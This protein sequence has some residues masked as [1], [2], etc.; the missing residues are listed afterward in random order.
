M[1]CVVVRYGEL[2]TK[3]SRVR[4]RMERQLRDNLAAVLVDRGIDGHVERHD[5]R[6]VV[7][8]PMP[9]RAADA[10]AEIPGVVSTSPARR[11]PAEFDRIQHALVELA[12]ANAP[13]DSYAVR[14]SRGTDAH[15]FTSLE[16]ERSGGSAIGVTTEATVDLDTPDVTFEADVR[17]EEAFVFTDRIDGP[18]GLPV[19]SQAPLVAL[20]SGG[21]DSPVAAFEVM[22]RG[23]PIVPVYV[24]LGSYGGPDH[25]A[26]AL[27][28]CG[29]LRRRAPNHDGRPY[30]IDGSETIQL[31]ADRVERGRM[32]SLRRYFF[33]AAETIADET[34]AAGIVTG[35]VIGQKSSQT[36][37][38]LQVTSE[39][40]TLPIHRPLLSVDKPV[41]IERAKAL[42]TYEEAAIPAGCNRL[43]PPRPETDGRIEGLSAVEPDDLLERARIDARAATRVDVG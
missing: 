22:R 4:G 38:N 13:F 12:E 41:L 15:R 3:S 19:G 9:S 40:T 34:D 33:A 43:A 25:R 5:G 39:A 30:V 18:G 35:E 21:V 2:G 10:A 6:L 27:A 28:A 24:D 17:V 16:L 31:L 1:D 36:A 7:D 37:R 42:G 29:R 26:R 11:T 32:L 14:A 8:T 23:S 20:V